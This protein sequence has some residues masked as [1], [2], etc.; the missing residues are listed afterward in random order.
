MELSDQNRKLVAFHNPAIR[1]LAWLCGAPQLTQ[2][3]MT[4]QPSSY[5]PEDYLDIL[6]QWDRNP[7]LGPTILKE[8]P[9]RRLGFYFEQLYEALLTDLLGWK[10]LLKNAQIQSGGKTLGELDFVVLNTTDDRIEHHEIA[11]KYYLG[12]TESDGKNWWYGPNARDRLDLKTHSLLEHQSQRTR[13]PE[14][15]ALLQ[16]HHIDAQLTAR[17]FMPGYLFYPNT[18]AI[19]APSSAPRD[20]LRGRW[21]Y[22]SATPYEDT[23]CWVQ[24]LKP[25][26]IGPWTQSQRPL[27]SESAKA[28]ALIEQD[29]IPRLFA[30]LAYDEAL[31]QW[32][33]VE[34][35]FVVPG[36]WPNASPG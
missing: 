16:K 13:E 34:R 29:N 9:K 32:C 26:W 17:V 4:F 15:Q 5:L 19:A 1:H 20:H 36:S 18:P 25:H 10:I 6:L 30:K 2:S 21:V 31:Q 7:D 8:P 24:L 3:S 28:L 11:I 23:S 22:A 14:T 35:I 33:E 27:E 12:V